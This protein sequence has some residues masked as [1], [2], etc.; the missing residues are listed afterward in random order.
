MLFL[1][2]QFWSAVALMDSVLCASILANTLWPLLLLQRLMLLIFFR[3]WT[4][5]LD[6]RSSAMSHDVSV[7]FPEAQLRPLSRFPCLAALS[8]ASPSLLDFKIL[9]YIVIS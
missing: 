3:F 6:L 4:W 1:L 7:G 5:I 9:G 8:P 2:V